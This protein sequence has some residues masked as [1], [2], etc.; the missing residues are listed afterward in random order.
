MATL[1]LQKFSLMAPDYT[2]WSITCDKFSINI[3][4]DL[5]CS[6]ASSKFQDTQNKRASKVTLGTSY[7]ANL[8]GGIF[9]NLLGFLQNCQKAVYQIESR[10]NQTKRG[11]LRPVWTD[12]RE[13]L[14]QWKKFK[15]ELNEFLLISRSMTEKRWYGSHFI[16]REVSVSALDHCSSDL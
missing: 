1:T 10:Y 15:Q 8:E 6:D 3:K 5:K 12:S 13:H 14:S 2:P 7:Q 11:G 4:L 16:C 9:Q